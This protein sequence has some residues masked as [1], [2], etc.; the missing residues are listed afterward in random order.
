MMVGFKSRA[1]RMHQDEIQTIKELQNHKS[2]NSF[3]KANKTIVEVPSLQDSQQFLSPTN[4][5]LKVPKYI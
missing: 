3:M 5:G 4:G 1:A 2:I